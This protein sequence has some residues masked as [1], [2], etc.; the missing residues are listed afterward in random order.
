M[1][2]DIQFLSLMNQNIILFMLLEDDSIFKKPNF[3]KISMINGEIHPFVKQLF[4][5]KKI[6]AFYLKSE[7]PKVA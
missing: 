7:N 2:K 1:L 5:Q 4:Q 3:T 6:N